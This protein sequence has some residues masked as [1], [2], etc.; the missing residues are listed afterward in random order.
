MNGAWGYKKGY[1]SGSL[2]STNLAVR[3]QDH[4]YF[5]LGKSRIQ[6]MVH[7][8]N[9][10][11]LLFVF[12]VFW[13]KQREAQKR[14]SQTKI[15]YSNKWKPI[16]RHALAY[17]PYSKANL[18]KEG[19]KGELRRRHRGRQRRKTNHIGLRRAINSQD[20]DLLPSCICYSCQRA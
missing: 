2:D 8:L 3:C 9:A 1:L 10:I 13:G 20:I 5:L 17:K 6:V 7:R 18:L 19:R 15:K 12:W 14:K 16:W 4:E 11:Q